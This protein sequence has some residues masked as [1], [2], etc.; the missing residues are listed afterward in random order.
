MI[1]FSEN[2]ETAKETLLLEVKG[3]KGG[4]P[5]MSVIFSLFLLWGLV[6]QVYTIHESPSSCTHMN[7]SFSLYI[8][9]YIY[10]KFQ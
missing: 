9:I 4:L 3:A 2:T 8:Y 10:T 6:T 1:L 7:V 5:E